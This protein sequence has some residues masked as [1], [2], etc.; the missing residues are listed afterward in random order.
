[1][2]KLLLKATTK[3]LSRQGEPTLGRRP[4]GS[5]KERKEN[6]ILL[7]CVCSQD[8]GSYLSRSTPR[9]CTR[10]APHHHSILT[11]DYR[12]SLMVQRYLYPVAEACA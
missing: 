3:D 8:C 7:A 6:K 9:H 4:R 10:S 12:P 2:Q 5:C 11:L 1:V